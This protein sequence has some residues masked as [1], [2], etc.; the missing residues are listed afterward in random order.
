MIIKIRY[1][2]FTIGMVLFSMFLAGCSSNQ[3]TAPN[4]APNINS[5][6]NREAMVQWHQQHDQAPK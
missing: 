1:V 5:A 6:D 4:A 3:V 2:T